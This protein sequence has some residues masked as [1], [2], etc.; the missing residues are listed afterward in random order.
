VHCSVLILFELG[1]LGD[2]VIVV[3]SVRC[4][5]YR[6][7]SRCTVNGSIHFARGNTVCVRK[8]K[9][10]HINKTKAMFVT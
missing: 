10:N 5:L 8:I 9:L 2:C 6:L 1:Q 7:N 4:D 3:I